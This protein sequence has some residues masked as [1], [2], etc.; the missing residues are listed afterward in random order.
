VTI[1]PSPIFDVMSIRPPDIGPELARAAARDAWGID[2][3]LRRLAGERDCNFHLRARDGC[4]FVLKFANPAEDAGYRDMQIEALRHIARR[5]PDVAVPRVIALPD[6]AA[7][8]CVADAGGVRYHVRLL[9]WVDGLPIGESCQ[10]AA[11]CAAVGATLAQLQEA[12]AGFSHPA[13]H[14]EIV[15]DLQHALRM[16]EVAPALPADVRAVL[17]DVLADFE[18]QVNPALPHLRRQVLHSDMNRANVLVD[19]QAHARVVGV[20]DFGDMAETPVVCDVAIAATSQRG[21]DMPIAEA[22]AHMLRAYAASR[23]LPSEEIV[24][25]P[26]LMA[27]RAIMNI[28]LACWHHHAQPGNDH[29]D[30]S[31][32]QIRTN[33]AY[34]A[35]LRAPAIQR[36]LLRA[37][38]GVA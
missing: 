19:P 27:T 8:T 12:L 25:L 5:A 9:S 20:I 37:A 23:P 16:R 17:L 15:W 1:K 32:Q 30:V 3:T 33:L 26:L 11:Q 13:S 34:V 31:D 29:Y 10:S 28:T 35:E 38:G 2:A 14:N 4:A 6:G 36:A 7:E 21:R 24:L 18:A 22:A